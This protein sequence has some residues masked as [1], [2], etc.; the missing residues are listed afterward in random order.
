MGAHIAVNT[1]LLL[2]GRR[3]GISRF[4]VEVLRRM[5][6]K[7]PEVQFSFLFDRPY[8]PQFLFHSNVTPFVIPPPARHPLLWHMWFH[9]AVP[10]KLRQLNPDVFFSPEFYLCPPSTIP[11]VPVFH[12]LAYEHYPEDIGKWAARF[13]RKYSPIYARKADA[14]LTVS[15]YSKQDIM[16]Q[17]GIPG[18]KITVAYNGVGDSFTPTASP[19]Q[20]R[21]RE[22]YSRGNPYFLF[23]GTVQPRKNLDTLL[24]AFDS[25]KSKHSSPVQLLIAGRKGWNYQQ[26]E[27]TYQLMQ[28]RE[29]VIF[30]GYVEEEELPA[31]FGSALALCYI[32]YLEGF[33][34]PLL[35]AMACDTPILC[36]HVSSLPEVVGEAAIQVDPFSEEQIV[37]GMVQLYTDEGLRKQLVRAGRERRQLFSWERSYQ[38]VWKVL[39]QYV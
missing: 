36:S 25:F 18:D 12:D 37:E 15:E 1:R 2:P 16:Y 19:L 22:K 24:R 28:A 11:Q 31:L 9:A 5:V 6:Q 23:V 13:C 4:A 30:T 34:I 33:G 10:F 3:E 39:Q 21:I 17:Y 26:I 29:E 14:I 32:P 20:Q 8:D 35:E 38:A 27:E 7:N